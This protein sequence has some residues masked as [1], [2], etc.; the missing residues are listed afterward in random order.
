[1]QETDLLK[2]I[3]SGDVQAFKTLFESYQPSVFNLCY[4]FA[5]NRQEAEDL[6]QEVF[7]KIYLAAKTFGQQSKISTWIYRITINLCLNYKRRLNKLSFFSISDRTDERKS[8]KESLVLAE[9]NQPDHLVELKEK[10]KIVQ[11]A[12]NSLP[13]NQ[14]T[15][16]I[17]QRYENMSL[18]EI[19]QVMNSSVSSIQSR[20][21]RAKENLCQRLLPYLKNF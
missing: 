9:E 7:F 10:E 6:C 12:I 20:L 1:V 4:R 11:A 3:A 5:K 19:A 18:Q 17:L 21:A 14:R 13:K 2:K 16:L 8:L 15:A